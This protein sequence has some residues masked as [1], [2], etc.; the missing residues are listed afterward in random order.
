MSLAYVFKDICKSD[1]TLNHGASDGF[2]PL[3]V[4]ALVDYMARNYEITPEQRSKLSM[5]SN[6]ADIQIV[7]MMQ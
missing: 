2:R 6:E 5:A 7:K 3:A 1:V 4:R